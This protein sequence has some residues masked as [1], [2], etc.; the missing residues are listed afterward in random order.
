MFGITRGRDKQTGRDP[1]V[2]PDLVLYDVALTRDMPIT[3]TVQSLVNALAHVASVIS[4]GS[5]EA[6]ADGARRRVDV[7]RAI[8][9]LLLAPRDL[10]AREHAL[11]RCIGVCGRVRS[12][13]RRARS[14]R[15]P[16]SS[17]VRSVSSTRRCTRSCCRISSRTCARR[18]RR[19]APSSSARSIGRPRRVPS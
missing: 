5:L 1:R 2:R 18:S 10:G 3:L 7:L 15:S 9:D 12:S 6:T 4:T 13:E 14:T 8:E 17:V 11:A 19:G 16:T